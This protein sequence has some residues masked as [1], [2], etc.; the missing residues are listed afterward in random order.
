MVFGRKQKPRTKAQRSRLKPPMPPVE[1]CS[2][3]ITDIAWDAASN[4]Y[5]SDGYV[6]SRIAKIDKDGK[7]AQFWGDPGPGPAS[8]TLRKH[9][10]RCARERQWEWRRNFH[11]AKDLDRRLRDRDVNVC[12]GIDGDAVAEC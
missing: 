5:I 7:L 6:N 2:A 12:R 3:K 11:H 10:H 1:A 4:A 8:S 9:R